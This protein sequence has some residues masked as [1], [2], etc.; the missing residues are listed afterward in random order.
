LDVRDVVQVNR[1]LI[2]AILFA[3]Y[4]YVVDFLFARERGVVDVDGGFERVSAGQ[5]GGV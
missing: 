1:F 2:V 4:R 3:K 5:F